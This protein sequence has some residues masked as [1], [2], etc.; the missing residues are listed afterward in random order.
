[1]EFIKTGNAS[2]DEGIKMGY[3]LGFKSYIPQVGTLTEQEVQFVSTILKSII[4]SLEKELAVVKE[5]Q[6]QAWQASNK[7]DPSTA[8]NY[9]HFLYLQNSKIYYK[10]NLKKLQEI[11][12]KLKRFAGGSW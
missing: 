9:K 7:D 6:P 3:R 4:S 1:M 8:E 5:L 11:Q 10:K 12:R 2:Y